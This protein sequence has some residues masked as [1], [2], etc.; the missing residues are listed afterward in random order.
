VP[1]R[2]RLAVLFALAT[3]V[4][5]GVSSVLFVRSL[6][7]EIETS[8]DTALRARADPLAQR[9]RAAPESIDITDPTR[10]SLLHPDEAVAQVLDPSGKLTEASDEAGDRPLISTAIRYA[11][12]S[13]TVFGTVNIDNARF[14]LLAAPARRADGVWT[15]IV[16]SSLQSGDTAV[17][18]VEHALIIG[19]IAAVVLAG[20]GG[21]LLATAALRPVERMRRDA[22]E[23]SGHDVASRLAVPATRD[24]IAA[25]ARTINDLLARQQGALARERTFVADAGHE[26]RTPLAV[27][28]TEL[29]LARNPNRTHDDL[30]DA[31]HHAVEETDRVV[32]LTEELLFLARD[33]HDRLE[34]QVELEPVVALVT[35]STEA[36]ESRT[37]A[38][39]VAIA[40]RGDPELTAKLD[41]AS[42]RRAV[43]NLFENALRF[44]PR[45]STI[46]ADV[47][48]EGA[49]LVVEVTD[50][51]P[52]FQAE[53][54]PHAFERFRRA[55]GARARVD[56]GSGLGLA[57]VLAVAE[58]HGGSA[59]AGNGSGG[60]AVVR[61]AIP[62]RM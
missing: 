52:G 11:A 40:V 53:F 23:I 1:I 37:T 32:S 56:G 54:L 49:N 17:T 18:R 48:T 61:I 20:F 57:I 59:T 24:E 26:L 42:F 41:A 30:R 55:D 9:V 22:A 50:H 21:W 3:L 51:G 29:E 27:L 46:I 34:L 43:D 62:T 2:I 10:N 35:R 16:A 13:K 47:R 44:A 58:A 7:R 15:V 39:G 28:R 19:G 31:V 5:F 36:L 33:D 12:S 4:L 6:R 45:G 60:G 38:A 8:L 14:R 25:L